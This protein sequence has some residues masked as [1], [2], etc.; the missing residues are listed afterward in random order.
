MRIGLRFMNKWE[1]VDVTNGVLRPFAFSSPIELTPI[2][3][4][5]LTL[6]EGLGS[7][8]VHLSRVRRYPTLREWYASSFDIQ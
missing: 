8:R 6:P 7:I 3:L 2:S 4:A 5:S 1:V